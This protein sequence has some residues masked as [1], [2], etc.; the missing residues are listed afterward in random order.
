VDH[1]TLVRDMSHPALCQPMRQLN[2]CCKLSTYEGTSLPSS[3]WGGQLVK[4]CQCK[5]Q[6]LTNHRLA[7]KPNHPYHSLVVPG[8]RL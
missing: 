5:Q 2:L 3:P 1:G 8:A 4:R 7:T 6:Q